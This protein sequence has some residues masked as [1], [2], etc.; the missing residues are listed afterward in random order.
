MAEIKKKK[1]WPKG[2]KRPSH[3][4]TKY[5]LLG[6]ANLRHGGRTNSPRAIEKLRQGWKPK[7][8]ICSGITISDE[9]EKFAEEFFRRVSEENDTFADSFMIELAIAQTLQ[10]HR[11]YLYAKTKNIG[12]D[13]SRMI[14]TLLS[15]MREMNATKNSRKENNINVNVQSDIMTL[16]QQTI[17]NSDDKHEKEKSNK[18]LKNENISSE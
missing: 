13:A 18:G 11:K 10:V 14:G 16:I 8:L 2:K 1:G 15:T 3:V 7:T 9:E 4:G 17:N 5:A 12:V 6:K